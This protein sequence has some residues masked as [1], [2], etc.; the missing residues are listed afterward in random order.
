MKEHERETISDRRGF[1]GKLLGG[2]LGLGLLGVLGAV[3]A[4]I[5][6]PHRRF[7]APVRRR[8]R[9]AHAR[10]IPLGKGKQVL[11]GGEPV[12]VLHLRE[13]LIA[14]SARCTHQG[15]LVQW[16]EQRG[17][18]ACPCHGGRFDAHGNVLAGLPTR[19]LPQLRAEMIQDEIY[20]APREDR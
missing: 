4:Y 10:E 20:L 17:T 14:L 9:V 16:D 19:P 8:Q 7:V 2:A 12:W 13:G 6:P 5:L 15:C 1:L 18:F 3:V 11:F